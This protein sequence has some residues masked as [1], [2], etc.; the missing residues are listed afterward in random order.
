MSGRTDSDQR[1]RD[2]VTPVAALA[3]QRPAGRCQ[4]PAA[5][6][7][8]V[9]TARMQMAVTVGPGLGQPELNH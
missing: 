4:W 2:R 9:V 1:D 8:A 3:A 7:S 6:A 5:Q